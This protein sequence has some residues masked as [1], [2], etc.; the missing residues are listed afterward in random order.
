MTRATLV[1]VPYDLGRQGV[2]GGVGATVLAEALHDDRSNRVTVTL[3]EDDRPELRNEIAASMAVVRALAD[4]VRDVVARGGL[5]VVL[6]ANCHSS[7]GTVAGIGGGVG[8]VWFDAHADFNTSD[9]TPSGFFD[10]MAA[11]MLTGAGWANLRSQVDGLEPVPEEHFVYV[12]MREPDDGERE[13]LAASH[14]HQ[15]AGLADLGTALDALRQRVDAVY[16]HVDLDVLDPSAGHANPWAA[17]DGLT[18]DELARAIDVVAERFAIRAA[19]F[20]A[21]WPESDPEGAVSRAARTAF[22]R[23]L[24]ATAVAA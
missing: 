23:I 13:R 16:V 1:E 20:T 15:A 9:S 17:E 11:A 22:D 14:V 5:P 21:Y 19:A 10:G 6:A 4:R 12:G 3:E 7:L 8:V 24:A 18:A 2:N